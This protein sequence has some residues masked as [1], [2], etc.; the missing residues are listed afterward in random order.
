LLSPPS[1]RSNALQATLLNREDNICYYRPAAMAV[2]PALPWEQQ[3]HQ[4]QQ[5]QQ[6]QRQQPLEQ[7]QQHL[8]RKSSPCS[9]LWGRMDLEDQISIVV[10]N[11]AQASTD[12]FMLLHKL[13]QLRE[14]R[15]L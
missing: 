15:K 11:V 7:E 5:Q 2:K 4:Q 9:R 6:Q 1:S 3:P 12:K 8:S 13:R 10:N 14:A